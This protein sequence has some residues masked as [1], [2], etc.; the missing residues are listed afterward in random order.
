MLRVPDTPYITLV[1]FIKFTMLINI[2]LIW[3]LFHSFHLRFPL[4]LSPTETRRKDLLKLGGEK[5]PLISFLLP[6]EII[7]KSQE[8]QKECSEDY[9][10]LSAEFRNRTETG[11]LADFSWITLAEWHQYFVWRA[12]NI[13][14]I[15]NYSKNF[16]IKILL[17][18]TFI[19]NFISTASISMHNL[20]PEWNSWT[21]STFMRQSLLKFILSVNKN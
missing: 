7:Q 20:K 10:L 8:A 4:L 12:K 18:L 14:L 21:E 6:Q 16:Q 9:I 11:L 19:I 13:T 2:S 5:R 1:Q 15:I 17:S 3:C